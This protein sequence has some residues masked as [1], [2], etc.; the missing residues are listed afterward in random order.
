MRVRKIGSTAIISTLLGTI[1]SAT[2][3]QATFQFASDTFATSG[4]YEAEIEVT[5]ASS[6]TQTVVDLLRFKVRAEFG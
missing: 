2:D 5:D 1:T 3:G 4:N 6:R